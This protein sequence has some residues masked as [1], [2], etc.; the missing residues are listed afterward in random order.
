MFIYAIDFSQ[1]YYFFA[2]L[3][4]SKQESYYFCPYLPQC[5]LQSLVKTYLVKRPKNIKP[6]DEWFIL[7]VYERA[8]I[9]KEGRK[10]LALS[11]LTGGIGV[12][13]YYLPYHLCPTCFPSTNIKVW[14]QEW[15]I[16]ILLNLYSLLLG[17]VEIG[18]LTYLNLNA[19]H[20]IADVC[21]YPDKDDPW[22]DPYL[23][24]LAD[25][26]LSKEEK[27]V[28]TLGLN[29]LLGIPK[30]FI[31]LITIF[32]F[33][34]AALSNFLI[35]ILV[36]RVLGRFFLAQLLDYVSV[37][38]Y[39]LW[40]VYSAHKVIQEAKIRVMAPKLIDQVCDIFHQ[41]FQ[42][43]PAFIEHLHQ[44]LQAMTAT[45]RRF[46]YAHYVYASKLLHTFQIPPTKKAE[47]IDITKLL[48]EQKNEIK[49][50]YFFVL[51]FGFIID[52]NLGEAEKKLIRKL[53]QA[54]II[55]LS[56]DIVS[57]W[58]IAYLEGYG[59]KRLM[60]EIKKTD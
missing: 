55:N 46:H 1:K 15:H 24:S 8:K 11:A 58:Q 6:I 27:G 54:G 21:G 35:R 23:T 59:M 32:N 34:K 16:P 30:V 43:N 60:E 49:Y 17:I 12:I 18:V 4:H 22:Y 53:N 40:N 44:V 19:V 39:A 51:V 20:K 3:P 33:I 7:N 42:D 26:S 14:G 13:L 29:P 2:C 56:P 57:A 5:M 31:F 37:P 45:S 50:A 41:K 47:I 48:E 25:A 38:V 36:K 10:L 52:G 28:L 9:K